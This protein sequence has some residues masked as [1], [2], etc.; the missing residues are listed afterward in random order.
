VLIGSTKSDV[1]VAGYP[2]SNKLY[3]TAPDFD[4]DAVVRHE[5]VEYWDGE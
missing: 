1:A 4:V 5:T 3:V 2:D